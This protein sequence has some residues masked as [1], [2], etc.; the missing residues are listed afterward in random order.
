[1]TTEEIKRFRF[2]GSAPVPT[3]VGVVGVP[4]TVAPAPTLPSNI[5]QVTKP[6]T[7]ADYN[8]IPLADV[9]ILH[10]VK[11]SDPLHRSDILASELSKGKDL[12]HKFSTNRGR[13]ESIINHYFKK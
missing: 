11:Q 3:S 13:P 9:S 7:Q 10:S 4:I 5:A 1:M 6:L 2:T 8:N 12:I